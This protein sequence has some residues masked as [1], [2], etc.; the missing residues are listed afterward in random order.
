MVAAGII[1][2]LFECYGH[3]RHFSPPPSHCDRACAGRICTG[4]RES[5]MKKLLFSA[6]IMMIVTSPALAAG[7]GIGDCKGCSSS[8]L[9]EVWGPPVRRAG[10]NGIHVWRA[11]TLENSPKC[12]LRRTTND[13]ADA[14]IEATV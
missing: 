5:V 11:A 12:E 9:Q 8:A 2:P 10:P 13:G 7:L 4:P 3:C 14:N 6:A 1:R